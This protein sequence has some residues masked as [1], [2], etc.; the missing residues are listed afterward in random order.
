ML[1]FKVFTESR[2]SIKLGD[3]TYFNLKK[4][5]NLLYKF[6]GNS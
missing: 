6:E 1:N 2:F 4:G 5:E 3:L